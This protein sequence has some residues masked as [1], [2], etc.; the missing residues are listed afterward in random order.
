MRFTSE[1]VLNKPIER[2]RVLTSDPAHVHQWQPDLLSITQHS[3]TPGAAGS[4][5]TLTYR[6]F[7]L[8]ET[9]LAATADERTSRYETRGMVHTITNRYTRIDD[10]RTKLVS[11]NEFQLS[12]LLKLGRR[13]LEKSLREQAERNLGNFKAFIDNAAP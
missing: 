11:D 6:K 4:T 13:V 8:E 9:V 7:T 5:A 12:G 2:V 1:I 10:Q 3:E